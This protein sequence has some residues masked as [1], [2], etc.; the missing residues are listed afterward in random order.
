MASA[1]SYLEHTAA[2]HFR[3][4]FYATIYHIVHALHRM[5]GKGD[6]G[7][8]QILSEH[9][10]IARYLEQVLPHLP[11]NRGWEEVLLWWRQEIASWESEVTTSLPLVALARESQVSFEGRL[12]IMIIALAEEDPRFG[13]LFETLQRPLASRRPS[14]ALIGHLVSGVGSSA[15]ADGWAICRALL[16]SG[17]IDVVNPDAPRAE[18]ALKLPASVWSMIRGECERELVPGWRVFAS[19]TFPEVDELI[20]DSTLLAQLHR[21]PLLLAESKIKAL[22]LKG[23]PGSDQLRLMG[24]VARSLGRGLVVSQSARRPDPAAAERASKPPLGALC[25]MGRYLPVFTYELAPGEAAEVPAIPGYTGP[26][27]I[28]LGLEGGIVG[29]V[30]EVALTLNISLPGVEERRRC[31]TQALGPRRCNSLEQLSERFILPAG[32][33]RSAANLAIGHTAVAGRELVE[34]GDVREACR[35][36]NRQQLDTH[37]AR[38]EGG[39]TWSDLIVSGATRTRLLDL[40]RRCRHREQLLPHLGGAFA[41]STN[42]GVRALFTGASGMGKTLAAR[43]LAAEIGMDLYRVDLGAVVNKYIGETEKNLHQVLSRS[44]ALDVILLLDEGDSLLAN[45]TEVKSANDRYANLE[46]NYLL[47]RLETYQGIVLITTNAAQQID[48]AFQRRM[49][50]VVPF[51][52]PQAEERRAIWRLHLPENHAVDD[53]FLEEVVQRCAFS[54]GQIRNAALHATLLAVD[55]GRNPVRRLH[56][57]SAVRSE[58]RKAGATCPLDGQS[59]TVRPHGVSSFLEAMRS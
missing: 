58:Y 41:G 8:E 40:Q 4:S 12:A 7:L 21:V 25:I 6:T 55:D 42:R 23:L 17:L 1:F 54:G 45:R 59:L 26:V 30:A 14:L 52:P 32:H 48:R 44:E 28:I 36:L 39:G 37:A 50:V 19:Q 18:W 46:T 24:A 15:D 11:D 35:A 43:I 49:D 31:W 53:C 22:V 29:A 9:R 34:I 33:I 56:L 27:G 2:G 47:Q 13:D 57:E 51:L 5:G 3:L 10:F 38:V 20:V 16:A